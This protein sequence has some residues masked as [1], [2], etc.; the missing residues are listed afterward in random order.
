M[1]RRATPSCRHDNEAIELDNG[2]EHVVLHDTN[3][4]L[5]EEGDAIMAL[6]QRRHRARRG[7]EH[8]VLHGT[9]EEVALEKEEV[10]VLEEGVV[11]GGNE[12]RRVHALSVRVGALRNQF[13]GGQT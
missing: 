4:V 10:V 6:R 1:R 3:V 8:V 7:R 2:R 9:A 5:E 11:V 12:R 13:Q